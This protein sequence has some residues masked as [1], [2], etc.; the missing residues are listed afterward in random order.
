MART[1][2]TFRSI[3]KTTRFSNMTKVQC[4]LPTVTG[5]PTKKNQSISRANTEAHT[6]IFVTEKGRL[7]TGRRRG[8]DVNLFKKVFKLLR[9][10]RQCTPNSKNFMSDAFKN[11]W[12]NLVVPIYKNHSSL[13]YVYYQFDIY[14]I[15]CEDKQF[16]K[17]ISQI[18]AITLNQMPRRK[19]VLVCINTVFEDQNTHHGLFQKA[20]LKVY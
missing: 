6:I 15:Q 11:I 3:S 16:K 2:E 5:K 13:L 1:R 9:S 10:L 17:K 20:T 18:S 7:R 4:T 19:K 8:E 12:W 14:F